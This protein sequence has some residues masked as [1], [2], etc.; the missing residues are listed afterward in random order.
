MASSTKNYS[1]VIG[2]AA[3]AATNNNDGDNSSTD[4]DMPPLEG[5]FSDDDMPPLV[6]TPAAPSV[7]NS[8]NN[9]FVFGTNNNNDGGDTTDED[10]PPLV[11]TAAAAP[12]SASSPRRRIVRAIRPPMQSTPPEPKSEPKDENDNEDDERESGEDKESNDEDSDDEDECDDE[13]DS[14]DDHYSDDE[15]EIPPFLSRA[16]MSGL[17]GG[18]DDDDDG[19]GPCDCP[20]CRMF[21]MNQLF[22]AVS[23]MRRHAN[24]ELSEEEEDDDDSEEEEEDSFLYT[25]APTCAICLEPENRRRSLV[26]LPCCGGDNEA[27]S[28]TR[29]CRACVHKCLR[30]SC[31]HGPGT[32]L[33]VGECP[34]CKHLL[35][36]VPNEK[37][38]TLKKAT[39]RSTIRFISRK[40]EGDYRVFLLT[41]AWCHADYLPEE[42][43]TFSSIEHESQDKIR[44]LVQWGL[45]HKKAD[46][47]YKIDVD[48]QD[49]LREF[50]SQ[51]LEAN[52]EGD[53]KSVR[54][55]E[56]VKS[57]RNKQCLLTACVC[58]SSAG[59]ALW[60]SFRVWRCLRLWN[61]GLTLL[62][63]ASG[64]LLPNFQQWSNHP[65]IGC[66]LT[67]VLNI[68]ILYLL[69]KI[70]LKLLYVVMY[71]VMGYLGARF[72]G[73]LLVPPPDKSWEKLL[74]SASGVGMLLYGCYVL[75]L[76]YLGWKSPSAETVVE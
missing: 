63:M 41:M 38:G 34:R 67:T 15:V 54:F 26:N 76:L 62:L 22:G 14:D 75:F 53:I 46:T 3:A 6:A 39:V 58:F 9:A 7:N 19:D 43:L 59:R 56:D 44:H 61:R 10:M 33:L 72:V 11:T 71:L 1:F 18:D 28:S 52:F 4:D 20:Q 12:S 45:L 17:G 37:D 21:L 57:N 48:A 5:D 13:E 51:Y 65:R 60:N 8:T 23:G 31:P 24:E 68:F 66:C 74:F 32:R 35:V 47:V 16:F 27:T 42:A 2:A 55:T 49:T 64:R 70:L 25:N 36:L 40:N 69:W 73:K 30:R 29:F 50:C